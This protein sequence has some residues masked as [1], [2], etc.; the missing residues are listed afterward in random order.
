MPI[1]VGIQQF[2]FLYGREVHLIQATALLAL[3]IPV[4]L[5]FVAQ[6]YFMQ[7]VKF[8]G[9]DKEHLTEKDQNCLTQ[10]TKE[11]AKAEAGRPVLSSPVAGKRDG[12]DAAR[13]ACPTIKS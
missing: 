13:A 7:G 8:T 5:F 3:I 12:K 4:L 10:Q 11:N 6:R 1:S 9:V 2:N